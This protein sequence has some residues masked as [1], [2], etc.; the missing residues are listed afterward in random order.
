MQKAFQDGVSRG[1]ELQNGKVLIILGEED[2]IV[3]EDEL[4]EDATEALGWD[5][6]RFEVCHAAHELPTT[7]SETVVNMMWKFWGK[8]EG[9]HLASM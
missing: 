8:Y 6:V 2:P 4:V 5:N 7:D 9:V 3:V 1:T